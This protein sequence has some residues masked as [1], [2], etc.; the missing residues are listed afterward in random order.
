MFPIG[1]G[2]SDACSNSSAVHKHIWLEHSGAGT[3][4]LTSSKLKAFFATVA[5]ATHY[6]HNG[7]K[8]F[9]S[10]PHAEVPAAGSHIL[11][12]TLSRWAPSL[13]WS[14][15]SFATTSCKVSYFQK[16]QPPQQ[17][18]LP[19]LLWLLLPCRLRNSKNY[20]FVVTSTLLSSTRS[21]FG[22]SQQP[23]ES[24]ITN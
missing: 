7:H 11:A 23:L 24:F 4:G 20:L 17:P 19:Q 12:S 16:M 5:A 1:V 21:S 3:L 8:Y 13:G 9:V 15:D 2:G 18:L 6:P 14:V 10:L 22:E